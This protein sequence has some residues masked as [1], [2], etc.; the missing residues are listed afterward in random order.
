MK[1][2]LTGAEGFIGSKV[3]ERLHTEG[4]GLSAAVR[5]VQEEKRLQALGIETV[6][7]NLCD[8]IDL[9]AALKGHDAVIHC[10]A[11]VRLW[12]P[13]ATF[14]GVN[15]ELT[16]KLI[17]ASQVAGIKRF[18]HMSTASVVL[19]E[20]RPLY[21]AEESL[22]LCN[23]NEMPYAQSKAQ[24]EE[25]VLGANTTQLAT[26]VLRPA[27]VWGKGDLVDRQI[28][29]AA[30]H[31]KFGWFNQ[32]EYL[33]SSCYIGNLCEAISLAVQSSVR[34]E[35]FFIADNE[36]LRF[37]DW[38]TQ[39]LRV[40]HYRVPTFSIPRALA[41]PFARFTENGWNY[42]PLKG[43]PPL[44]RE[45]VRA[46]GYPLTLSIEKAKR[47]LSYRAPYS[48]EEGMAAIANPQEGQD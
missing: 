35:A 9:H 2:F 31:G 22:P 6:R 3:L 14:Q 37:R 40:G 18:I 4:H 13:R 36:T 25:A 43:D 33:Y 21:D 12:G 5:S 11:Y 45:A 39:R 15:V 30:N 1:I 34:A 16:K 46:T 44:V 29:P 8:E 27:F 20:R 42:L 47:I 28:G 10:A 7:G 48:I 24:A 38:M 26:V 32:G 17:A 19:N 41:W 23:R